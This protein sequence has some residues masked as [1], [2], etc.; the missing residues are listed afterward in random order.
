MI[1]KEFEKELERIIDQKIM[2]KSEINR[3]MYFLI[4]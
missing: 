2:E 4:Q 1:R 3:R